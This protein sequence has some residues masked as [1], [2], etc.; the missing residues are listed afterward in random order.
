M[1]YFLLSV[2]CSLCIGLI[3]KWYKKRN[4]DTFQAIVF[5]YWV[6]VLTGSLFSGIWPSPS[7]LANQPWLGVAGAL[8]LLFITG[9]YAIA[10]TVQLYGLTIASVMQKMSLLLSVPFSIWMF[11]EPFSLLKGLGLVLALVAVLLINWPKK[12]TIPPADSLAASPS[13]ELSPWWILVPIF[14]F[15]DSGAIECLLAYAQGILIAAGDEQMQALFST[16]LFGSAALL[17]SL[18]M[19]LLLLLG[20][21]RFAWKNLWGGIL[22]GVP[23]YFSIYFLILAFNWADKSLVL[24]LVNLLVVGGS[25]LLGY[26]LFREPLSK[27]NYF[28]LFAALLAILF[29]ALN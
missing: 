18:A 28:G 21:M 3:F 25:A 20:K 19:L 26:V 12:K 22:L 15:F 14:T 7:N 17:G 8:G 9:F 5:N 24:P 16:S 27:L 11:S 29:I 10:L 23:N 1:Q 13:V 2:A 6:C 4:I